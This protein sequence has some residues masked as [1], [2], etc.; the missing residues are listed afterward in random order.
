[1]KRLL[2]LVTM[3]LWGLTI[4]SCRASGGDTNNNYIYPTPPTPPPACQLFPY[5]PDANGNGIADTG[6]PTYFCVSDPNVPIANFTPNPPPPLDKCIFDPTC[7]KPRPY[8]RINF[9]LANLTSKWTVSGTCFTSSDPTPFPIMGEG[10]GTTGNIVGDPIPA[11]LTSAGI[12]D[13]YIQMDTPISNSCGPID[14]WLP[15]Q[16]NGVVV[17]GLTGNGLVSLNAEISFTGSGLAT[18]EVNLPWITVDNGYGG[19]NYRLN[20]INNPDI[21][22]II[23]IPV[24]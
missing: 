12:C 24:P 10:Y 2:I 23:V 5:W 17:D 4:I 3:I 14:Y 11:M 8:L 18:D 19:G 16:N 9:V 13:F 15:C 6:A 20:G 1:M 22:I 7:Q 21:T